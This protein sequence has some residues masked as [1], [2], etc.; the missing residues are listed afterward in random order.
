MCLGDGSRG[1]KGVFFFFF[2]SVRYHLPL[3]WS[4]LPCSPASRHIVASSDTAHC[5][6]LNPDPRYLPCLLR[7]YFDRVFSVAFAMSHQERTPLLSDVRDLPF[8][9]NPPEAE[10]SLPIF[11][12]VCYSTWPWPNQKALVVLRGIIL[13]YLVGVGPVIFHYK[14]EWEFGSDNQT[15]LNTIFDFSTVSFVLNLLYHLVAF[16]SPDL[17]RVV[18]VA[19]PELR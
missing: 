19:V 3:P 6:A 10:D 1:R 17:P 8:I 4:C 16:V 14:T 7:S 12:C 15:P 9:R 18:R 2:P 11:L 13:S 5:K